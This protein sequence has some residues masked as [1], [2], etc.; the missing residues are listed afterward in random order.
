[1]LKNVAL[2]KME[3]FRPFHFHFRNPSEKVI[4][5]SI[6]I[7]SNQNTVEQDFVH[8]SSLKWKMASEKKNNHKTE[9]TDLMA[10]GRANHRET[11]RNERRRKRRRKIHF[12]LT[13]FFTND[14]NP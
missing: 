5:V 12:V 9:Q 8:L 2:F 10:F 11:K 6:A 3:T 4:V 7:Q 1:M 13:D 14:T